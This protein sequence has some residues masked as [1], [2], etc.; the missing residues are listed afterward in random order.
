[1]KSGKIE[2]VCQLRISF[3]NKSGKDE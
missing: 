2:S 1:L 3:Q